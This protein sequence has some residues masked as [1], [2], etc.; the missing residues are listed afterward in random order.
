MRNAKDQAFID[1][2]MDVVDEYLRNEGDANLLA[3]YF[4]AISKQVE[5]QTEAMC[6]EENHKEGQIKPTLH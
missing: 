3:N 1:N 5:A 6:L 2:I 4:G